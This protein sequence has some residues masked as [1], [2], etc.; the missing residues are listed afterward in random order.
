MGN[1]EHYGGDFSQSGKIIR[2]MLASEDLDNVYLLDKEVKYIDDYLFIGGT[3]WTDFNDEDPLTMVHSQWSMNDYR[4]VKNRDKGAA[5]HGWKF[6]PADALADHRAM[7]RFIEH[8]IDVR[9]AKGDRSDRVVIVGHHCPSRLSTHPRYKQDHIVNGAYSSDLDE[10]IM[11][12]PEICLWTHGHTHED[13]DYDIGRTRIVCNPRG[14]IGYE[15]RAD[16]WRPKLVE[17][18]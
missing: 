17:L 13:F 9:R 14:Y 3:L 2:E 18:P 6:M 7:M 11:E 10:F 16:A 4:G 12:H 1:H 8:T 15:P 5:G